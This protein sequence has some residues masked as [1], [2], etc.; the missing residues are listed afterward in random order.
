L[1]DR[2]SL[3]VLVRTIDALSVKQHHR[4][5]TGTRPEKVADGG[6]LMSQQ[7]LPDAVLRPLSET[8]AFESTVERLAAAIRLGVIAC[9]EQLPSERDLAHQLGVSRVNLRAAIAALR[10]AKMVETRRG[11]GGGTVVTYV[12]TNSDGVALA[13]DHAEVLRSRGPQLRDALDFRRVVEPGAAYLAA[14]QDLSADERAWLV[15]SEAAVRRAA[16]GAPHRIA[17]SRLHLAIATLSGSNM[18]IEAVTRAQAALHEML[19]GIPVL[20][21]NIAHSH[22]QHHALVAAILAGDATTARGVME[23]HCDATSALLRGLLG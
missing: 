5:Y 9:G 1:D 7:R 11:R 8:N 10:D 23:Q 6:L 4:T 19:T 20:P 22:E 12:G 14:S 2:C 3:K 13:A 21:R 16:E 15:A 18:L 17:D